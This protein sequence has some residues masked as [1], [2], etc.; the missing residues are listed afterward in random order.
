M[1]FSRGQEVVCVDNSNRHP[2]SHPT[3][4]PV[5]YYLTVGDTYVVRRASNRRES[6]IW[7]EGINRHRETVDTRF[8][9]C[10]FLASRFRLADKRRGHVSRSEQMERA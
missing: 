3:D 5:S 1:V 10:G 4:R 7:L 2:L 6:L 9:D 8:G